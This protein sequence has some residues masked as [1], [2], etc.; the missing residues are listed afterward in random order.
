MVERDPANDRAETN[1]SAERYATH[2][3]LHPIERRFIDKFPDQPELQSLHCVMTFGLIARDCK[4]AIITKS[5]DYRSHYAHSAPAAFGELLEIVRGAGHG[6]QENLTDATNRSTLWGEFCATLANMHKIDS[7]QPQVSRTMLERKLL[8]AESINKKLVLRESTLNNQD[9]I[10]LRHQAHDVRTVSELITARYLGADD[11][12]TLA[13]SAQQ[14]DDQVWR[15]FS[16]EYY[17]RTEYFPSLRH[18][19]RLELSFIAHNMRQAHRVAV[20]IQDKR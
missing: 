11:L 6:Q 7:F 9:I 1:S 20:S 13:R 12:S 10:R 8:E 2:T 18:S 15:D 4:M 5:P 19:Q 16:D 14:L 17:W 3:E